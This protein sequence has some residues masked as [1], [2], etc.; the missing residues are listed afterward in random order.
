MFNFRSLKFCGIGFLKFIAL[1]N[2]GFV[3]LIVM[4][5]V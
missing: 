3:E 4:K 5:F 2:L 1:I